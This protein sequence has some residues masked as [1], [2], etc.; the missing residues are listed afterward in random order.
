MS[1]E[2]KEWICRQAPKS[3]TIR[4]IDGPVGKSQQILPG[5]TAI[6][7]GGHFPGSLVLHWEDQLFIADTI[8]T[9]PVSHLLKFSIFHNLFTSA[10]SAH[11]PHPRPSGQTSYTFQWSIPNMIPLAPDEISNIWEA[12]KSYDFHTTY[13]AFNGM[14]VHDKVL[15]REFLKA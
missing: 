6:K 3:N 8:M 5:V 11:T 9:V 13:G 10:Q 2:D 14:N 1:S 12:I 15:N 7:A 4:L